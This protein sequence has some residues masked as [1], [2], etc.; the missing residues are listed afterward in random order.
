MRVDDSLLDFSTVALATTL[1]AEQRDRRSNSDPGALLV[2]SRI[3]RINCAGT[4]LGPANCNQNSA[5]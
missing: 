1:G 4:V 2:G 3:V 5:M